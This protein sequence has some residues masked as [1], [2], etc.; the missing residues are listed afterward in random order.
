MIVIPLSLVKQTKCL[1]SQNVVY[2]PVASPGRLLKMQNLRLNL[3][4]TEPGSVL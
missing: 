4:P 3:K 2:G 1:A